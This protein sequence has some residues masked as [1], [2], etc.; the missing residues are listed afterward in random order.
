VDTGVRIPVG[1]PL[2]ELSLMN[3]KACFGGPVAFSAK[4]RYAHT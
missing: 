1:T 2:D 3:G 4:T